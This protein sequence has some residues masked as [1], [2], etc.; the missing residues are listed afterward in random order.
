MTPKEFEVLA[1][2]KKAKQDAVKAEYQNKEKDKPLTD[3][4]RLDRMEKLLGLK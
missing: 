1:R 3:K 2:A 4:E